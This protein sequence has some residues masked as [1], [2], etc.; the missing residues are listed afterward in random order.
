MHP[1]LRARLGGMLV[2]ARPQRRETTT[3]PALL[4]RHVDALNTAG[5]SHLGALLSAAQA[6]ELRDYFSKLPV[7]DDYRPQT[8]PFL[9]HGAGRHPD[10][11]VAHHTARDIAMAPYLWQLANDPLLLDVASRFLGCQA[12]IGYLAAWWSYHTAAGAQQAEHFH[13]DVDDWRFLK[14]FV[15]LTDVGDDNGP[16]IYVAHSSTSP[17]LAEIRRFD[18]AEVLAQFGGANVLRLTGVAGGAFFEN[19]FGIHKGQ[20]VQ[21]GMRLIFQVVYSVFPLPYGPKAP[22]LKRSELPAAA[23]GADAWVNRLY[24]AQDE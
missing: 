17:K 19:T 5:I 23:R 2:K 20:P 18:D 22:V 24:V 14:L 4:A 21:Q 6:A 9:P 3:P 7:F 1:A 15:Y 10:S 16:H 8:P 11:H 13:R 12:S